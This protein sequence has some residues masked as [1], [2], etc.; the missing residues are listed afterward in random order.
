MKKVI[1]LG[2]VLFS[3]NVFGQAPAWTITTRDALVGVGANRS[4]QRH[5]FYDHAIDTTFD[6]VTL[7]NLQ[8]FISGTIAVS[9]VIGKSQVQNGRRVP[10]KT[11]N[12][13]DGTK[14]K[15]VAVV[16]NDSARTAIVLDGDTSWVFTHIKPR[17]ILVS[18]MRSLLI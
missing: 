18:F 8:M 10:A 7:S 17:V 14:G 3:V 4:P 15:V 5:L 9:E 11:L 13:L 12:V 16:S 1:F 6:E 2:A